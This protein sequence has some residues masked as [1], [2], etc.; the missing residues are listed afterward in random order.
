VS[1]AGPSAG[2]TARLRL[3]CALRLPQQ[4]TAEVAAWQQRELRG[5][6]VV[7]VENLHLTLAFLGATPAGALA[8]VAAALGA[9][10]GAAGPIRLALD[11]YRET[12]SVAMLTFSDEGEHARAL[13]EALGAALEQLGL[14]R[15]EQRPWTPHLTVLRFTH[16][17]RLDPPLPLLGVV[18]PSDAAVYSSSLRH[19]GARYEVLEAMRL[20][21]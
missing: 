15:R 4:A 5:G 11:G 21:G 13:A 3:F 8:T 14:Y 17:P 10:A 9:A 7:P 18:S 12:R 20:G 19:D 6:R 1:D 2:G 16:R